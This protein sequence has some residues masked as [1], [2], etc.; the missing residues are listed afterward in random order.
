MDD[1]QAKQAAKQLKAIFGDKMAANWAL[2][3]A[4]RTATQAAGECEAAG[5]ADGE[6]YWTGKANI[7]RTLQRY[8]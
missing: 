6:D 5:N 3:G 1:K 2:V 4:I 7:A 8:L